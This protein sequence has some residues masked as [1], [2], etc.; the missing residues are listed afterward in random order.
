MS[1]APQT[2]SRPGLKDNVHRF[3]QRVTE[4]MEL[5]QLWSQFEKDARS[6]YR[7]YSAG[8]EGKLEEQSWLHRSWDITKKLF[9]AILDKLSPA[10][11]I[12]LLFGLV[13]LFFP[14]GDVNYQGQS[15]QV[16]FS[17]DFHVWGGLV[18]LLV[19]LLEL[20]DRVVMKR[21]L[22]IAKDIQTWL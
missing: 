13:L 17:I 2:Q 10:R 7:F 11:R 9:W 21:D 18:L 12:L 4:G 19:L 8:L 20:A 3:W 5:S 15:G 14:A 6:G 16:K 1:S 22:E